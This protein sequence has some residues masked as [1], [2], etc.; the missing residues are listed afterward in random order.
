MSHPGQHEGGA[1]TSSAAQV[2][3]AAG[4]NGGH[5]SGHGS[6]HGE[7]LPL[8]LAPGGAFIEKLTRITALIG[9]GLLI[10][11]IV[12]TLVS[13]AGRYLM[14]L[15]VPGDYELVEIACGVAVFLFFPFTHA[16]GSNIAAEFFTSGLPLGSRRFLDLVH[17]VIFFLLGILLT[18]RMVHA[19][20]EKLASG[21]TSILVGV[22][23]WWAYGVGLLSLAFLTVVCLLRALAGI[24]ALRLKQ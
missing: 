20:E 2:E 4:H 23:L 9:G 19:F 1:A 5:G 24:A 10:A 8:S 14:G 12:L 16:V 13:V 11:A 3:Q 7:A 21:E 18:W 17:D 6:A 22:P 15:P